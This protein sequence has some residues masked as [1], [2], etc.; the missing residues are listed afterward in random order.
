MCTVI[1]VTEN[2]IFAKVFLREIS[3]YAQANTGLKKENF[4]HKTV[5]YSAAFDRF[6][7]LKLQ[8]F[9]SMRTQVLLLN[10]R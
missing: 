3:I 9:L 1:S 7:F 2:L 4:E 8:N 5:F 6:G 10:L